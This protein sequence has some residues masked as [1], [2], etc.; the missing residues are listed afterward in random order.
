MNTIKW[1]S[2]VLLN[3][4]I[5]GG[6]YYSQK[7]AGYTAL[8][9]DLHNIVPVCMKKDNPELFQE[10][11]Y[12]NDLEN[13]RYYTPFFV[14]TLR[15]IKHAT[16]TDYLTALKILLF[17]T[18][19]IFGIGWFLL[20]YKVYKDFWIALFLSVLIRGIIWVPGMEIW[21][22]SEFWTMMPRTLYGALLPYPF[23]IF[24]LSHK[25]RMYLAAF[26]IG[27]IFNFH[28]ITG[29]GGILIF[30]TLGLWLY[31]WKKIRWQDLIF[32]TLFILLG[33]APF[34][35][36][37]FSHT[38]I[39]INNEIFNEALFTRIPD[40]F[41]DPLKFF[42]H[43]F[44]VSLL[45]FFIPIIILGIISVKDKRYK[46][47]FWVLT[48]VTL[49]LLLLPNL[50]VYMERIIN[51]TFGTSLRMSFQLLRIQKLAILPGYFAWGY[52]LLYVKENW[53]KGSFVIKLSF[54]VFLFLVSISK[55]KIW[56]GIPFMGD[57]IFRTILPKSL[58]IGINPNDSP[59]HLEETLTFIKNNTPEDALFIG[60][61]I[62]RS[63][64]S[65]SV[66]WD[67]KGASMLI[68]GNPERFIWWYEIRKK[69]DSMDDQRKWEFFKENGVDYW[70][71]K[72][73]L[74]YKAL[75]QQG[76]WKL[77]K[78]NE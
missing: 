36:N 37:Y 23:V 55:N 70:L 3:L 46:K 16:G 27:F 77:Y 12:L 49:A 75:Y 21:G 22:I 35:Y 8:S 43:W 14:E 38:P 53:N 42:T 67:G 54:F 61:A 13:V 59:N 24:D 17:I 57:D 11:L 56:N 41:S 44:R 20:F 15:F 74:P 1:L 29:L 30:I 72:D 66:W 71:T 18:H 7:N 19:L 6:F 73:S 2:V 5:A 48:S 45:F 47:Y 28:P 40:Y 25:K 76:E 69:L 39:S 10:D 65:R 68:E 50:S 62:I 78:L 60:P 31:I 9:S 34:I 58:S 26:L 52:I 64:T 51:N 63:S 32:Q 4:I 33:M